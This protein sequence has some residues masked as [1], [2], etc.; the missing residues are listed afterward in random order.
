M[1]FTYKNRY[2]VK[3]SCKMQSIPEIATQI[4]NNSLS[5]VG[6]DNSNTIFLVGSKS[7]VSEYWINL[8]ASYCG[9]TVIKLLLFSGKIYIVIFI[10]R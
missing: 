2:Y 10:L 9:Q 4:V 3:F 8:S 1:E 5:S 7:V 6:Q